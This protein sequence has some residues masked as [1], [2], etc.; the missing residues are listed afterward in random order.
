MPAARR[1]LNRIPQSRAA[2]IFNDDDDDDDDDQ[3]ASERVYE[4]D[5]SSRVNPVIL[6]Q[7]FY[8]LSIMTR[9]SSPDDPNYFVWP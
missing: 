6:Q 7:L 5:T 8:H 3:T 1:V 9:S 4:L 2:T